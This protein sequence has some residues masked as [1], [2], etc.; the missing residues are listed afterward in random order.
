M[1]AYGVLR[2]IVHLQYFGL[3]VANENVTTIYLSIYLSKYLHEV[4]NVI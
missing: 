4:C 3:V 1:K 2:L